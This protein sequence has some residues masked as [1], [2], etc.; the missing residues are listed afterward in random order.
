MTFF[1][2]L[3]YIISASE[4]MQTA[5]KQAGSFSADGEAKMQINDIL[6]QRIYAVKSR[7]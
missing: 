4:S 5:E 2:P 7:F 6:R 1:N 3:K